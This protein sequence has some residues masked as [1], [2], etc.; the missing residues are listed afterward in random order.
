MRGWDSDGC[1]GGRGVVDVGIGGVLSV[2]NSRMSPCSSHLYFRFDDPPVSVIMRMPLVVSET[3]DP[4]GRGVVPM[5]SGIDVGLWVFVPSVIR[6]N[7]L[8]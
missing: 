7:T 2:G 3:H 5:S 1:V 6:S 8:Y 4:F